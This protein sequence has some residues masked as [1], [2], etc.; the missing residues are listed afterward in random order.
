M[1]FAPLQYDEPLYRPPSEGRNLIVQATI[2]CSF[3]RCTFCAMYKGKHFHARPLGDVFADI[4][5]AARVWPDADRVFLADGDALVLPTETLAAILDRLSA[6]FPRLERVSSYATPINLTQKQPGELRLLR[7]KRLSLV[8]VGVESGAP[9]ILS[10]IRKGA[11]PERIAEA[12]NRARAAGLAV[13]ATVILGVGGRR[14]WREHVEGTAAVIN[15]APPAYLSTLQLRLG[16]DEIDEFLQ[17]FQRDGPPFEW[18]DDAGVLEEQEALLAALDPKQPVVFR[19]NHAS[20]CL[21]LAGT[22]PQDRDRLLQIVG[23]AR[24]GAPVLR[25]EFLRGL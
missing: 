2:G 14:L 15:A 25:P 23:A 8:Y 16:A 19:S 3:N 18:Q 13:S 11:T 5:A 1:M 4:E 17:R 10:R 9:A 7:E 21:P 12:L 24:R 6:A 20:N 22:L